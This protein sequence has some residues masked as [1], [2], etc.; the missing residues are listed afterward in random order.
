MTADSDIEH[1]RKLVLMSNK[2]NLKT[3]TNLKKYLDL[4]NKVFKRNEAVDSV[5][6]TSNGISV[7]LEMIKESKTTKPKLFC[8]MIKS[9]K[10][11]GDEFDVEVELRICLINMSTGELQWN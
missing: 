10:E 8:V 11:V 7:Q 2:E 5:F 3:V 4:Q 6:H 9:I 1:I